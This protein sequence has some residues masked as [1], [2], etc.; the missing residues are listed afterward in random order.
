MPYIS[1]ER[2]AEIRSQIKKE[3]PDYKFSIVRDGHSTVEIAILEAPFNML[4]NGNGETYEHV[5]H[6]YI[7]DHYKDFP[8]V[9]DVL[10]R[11]Y[12]IADQGNSIV[13]VDGDYGNIPKFYVGI[14]I[15][16][17]DK[18]FKVIE[19][20]PQVVKTPVSTDQ[21][22]PSSLELVHY[23]DRAIALFGDTKPIKDQLK[24][25]GGRFNA[26]LQQNG[27]K[28]AGWIFSKSKEPEL[29]KLINQ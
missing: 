21:V 14:R 28:I 22:S 27:K 11:I 13:S 9:R 8:Q 6:F 19:A 20:K 17:W 1:K 26:H 16:R 10:A 15:G 4:T 2:V 29:M 7:R 3:F 12:E 5:N 23:S 25:I 18:P 24:A